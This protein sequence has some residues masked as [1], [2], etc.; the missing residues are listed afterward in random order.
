MWFRILIVFCLL[1]SS[2]TNTSAQIMLIHLGEEQR[3]FNLAEI[4]SI[5]FVDPQLS[6]EPQELD[7]GSVSP[8]SSTFR[9]ITLTNTGEEMLNIDRITF[10]SEAFYIEA[11]L[12]IEVLFGNPHVLDV[13]FTPLRLGDFAGNMFIHYNAPGVE[14]RIVQLS[15]VGFDSFWVEETDINMSILVTEAT[16]NGASLQPGDRVL[17]YTQDE[18]L[19][20]IGIIQEGFPDEPMGFP[21]YGADQD[22]DNG[23]QQGEELDFKFWI[24]RMGRII[25]AEV[26]EV[27]NGADPVVFIGNGVVIVRLSAVR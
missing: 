22:Q 4:D 27:V 11:Q 20:G 15:G 13:F 26:V 2:F 23:F 6:V 1:I 8:D 17:A 12:P 7:F 18:L 10:S 14:V 5:N 19:A 25:D 16:L 21:V 24:A 9:N 3:E